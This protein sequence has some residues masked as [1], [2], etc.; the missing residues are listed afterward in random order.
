MV[1]VVPFP[2]P[3]ALPVA[4]VLTC[5][6]AARVPA[7]PADPP[8]GVW[9]RGSGRPALLRVRWNGSRRALILSP[10]LGGLL[11]RCVWIAV[12]VRE[13]SR[14]AVTVARSEDL[15]LTRAL[16]VVTALPYLPT[17]DILQSL[18]PDVCG[19][20]AGIEIPLECRSPEEVLA[21]CAAAR[22]PILAS[23]VVY[24]ST[25]LSQPVRL[26]AER[27]TSRG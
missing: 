8:L 6:C 26:V 11:R 24:Q 27:V 3:A 25:R 17:A 19:G 23:R 1:P 7:L 10:D 14:S 15:I 21:A 12:R 18:F 16:R 13:P 5:A 9:L 2:L 4:A 20:P 22:V